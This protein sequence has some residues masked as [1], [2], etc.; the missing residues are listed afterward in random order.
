MKNIRMITR[1]L[2]SV[3]KSEDICSIDDA[4]IGAA[5][6]P[7]RSRTITTIL[8]FPINRFRIILAQA[9]A[10]S[11]ATHEKGGSLSRLAAGDKAPAFSLADQNGKTVSL[12]DF[13]GKKLLVYFIPRP[14]PPAAPVR[15]AASGT[16]CRT[17]RPPHRAVGSAP[18]SPAA[19]KKFDDKYGLGFPLLSDP[20]HTVSEAYSPGRKRPAAARRAWAASA[21]RSS[22]RRREG[23]QGVV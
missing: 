6:F 16:P 10:V 1:S 7:R 22:W 3:F 23:G 21:R 5:P 15:H 13:A 18:T 9:S 11:T 12:A 20:D 2:I 14:T 19:L 8:S 17:S 4:P